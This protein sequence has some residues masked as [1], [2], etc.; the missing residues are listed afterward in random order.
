MTG[1]WREGDVLERRS[2]SRQPPWRPGSSSTDGSA[3]APATEPAAHT[4]IEKLNLTSD[5]MVQTV[6]RPFSSEF[7]ERSRILNSIEFKAH[8]ITRKTLLKSLSNK[9]L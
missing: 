3:A 4:Q 2:T 9:Y 7:C 5:L 1:P 8:S 6:V